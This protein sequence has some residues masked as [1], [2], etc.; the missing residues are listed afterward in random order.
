MIGELE[1]GLSLISVAEEFGINKSV[2]SRA[3]KAFQTIGEK[4]R[5]QSASSITQRQVLWFT[6]ARRPHRGSLFT[7]CPES[8]VPLKVG[9][10]RHRLEWCKEHKNWTPHQWSRVRFTNENCFSG[11]SYA[12]RQLIWR[13]AGARF[14]PSTAFLK[15][16]GVT[17]L[18]EGRK[19]IEKSKTKDYF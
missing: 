19:H 10:W 18:L 2:V 5:Y 15:L 11:M 6:V 12:Q 7:R 17:T 16:W 8:C 9:H 3:W 13:E 1:E 4:S 14:H